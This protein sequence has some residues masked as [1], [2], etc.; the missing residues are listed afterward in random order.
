M[1]PIKKNNR[2]EEILP[3]ASDSLASDSRTV[4]VLSEDGKEIGRTYPKRAKGL[5]KKS[6]AV[7]VT[8]NT[9]RLNGCPTCDNTE[10]NMM[11][12]ININT[13][14][15]RESLEAGSVNY[16]Y[17]K[18]KKWKK[19]PDVQRTTIFERFSIPDP[20]GGDGEMTDVL[21]T[22]SWNGAW[23]EITNGVEVLEKN[24][25]YRFVFW[26][27][28]GENDRY[29]EVCQ[30]HIIFTDDPVN[31]PLTDWDNKLC[32]KLNRGY[33]KPLKRCNGWELYSVPFKTGDKDFVQLRFVSQ[34]A[35]MAVM[36]AKAPEYYA[37]LPESLDPFAEERP[38]RHNIIFE[39]GWPT[40]QWYSTA[41]LMKKHRSE[42]PMGKAP[43]A[44]TAITAPADL[45]DPSE[46]A[47]LISDV[48]A[49]NLRSEEI[50]S[51]IT[52]SLSMSALAEAIA[53]NLDM[54]ALSAAISENIDVDNDTIAQMAADMIDLD[55]VVEKI[56]NEI[57]SELKG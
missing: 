47:R 12:N 43:T 42:K 44:P 49:E 2:S 48:V 41:N 45:I 51:A 17:L 28:G 23:C 14:K 13:E 20:F 1:T 52:E 56:K 36:E 29:N 9:I 25:E 38:Q 15:T 11:D 30:L 55:E 7:F 40:N 34:N 18:P 57:I 8:D 27:N 26:L 35:P 31:M 4:T 16:V 54:G 19:H 53:E 33:I 21:S 3:L 10:D 37:D 5:V 50:I 32:Y 46:T 24:T 6:R 22:G 39:D